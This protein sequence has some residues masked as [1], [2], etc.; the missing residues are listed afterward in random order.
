[1][2]YIGLKDY[3]HFKELFA[4]R[5]T[6]DGKLVRQNQILLSYYKHAIKNHRTFT[7][8]K[9]VTSMTSLYDEVIKQV[10]NIS[11]E[12]ANKVNAN[13]N[14]LFGAFGSKYRFYSSEYC[15]DNYLGL[16]RDGDATAIRYIRRED[17]REFKM[18][19]GKFLKRIMMET[20]YGKQL[21]ESTLL[22]VLEV[23]S[24]KWTAYATEEIGDF[25]LIV[26]EDFRAI[27]DSY[28]YFDGADFHSCMTDNEQYEFYENAVQAKAASIWKND[29]MYARC[30]IF[31]EVFDVESSEKLRL[32][33]RQ[34]SAEDNDLYKNILINKLISGGYI[35]GY[36][37]VG[38]GCSSSHA[39]VSNKGSDWSNRDFYIKCYLDCDDTLSY[40]DTFKFYNQGKN[41]AYNDYNYDYDYDLAT[42]DPRLEGKYDSYHDDYCCEVRTVY[43]WSDYRGEY[44]E[45]TCDVD[46][47]GDFTYIDGEYY[48]EVIWSDYSCDDIRKDLAVWSDCEQSYLDRDNA[49]YSEYEEDYIPEDDAIWD[50]KAGDYFSSEESLEEWRAENL[51]EEDKEEEKAENAA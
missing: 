4:K 38:A 44:R 15:S 34:Y 5:Q 11:R 39:F 7:E 30:I 23:F 16:C 14:I 43:V 26:D 36:K 31:T 21:N 35:D 40:Q 41:R 19:A 24:Q 17:G 42:T 50:D 47:M 10:H 25:E 37:Q 2:L 18:K 32:A 45:E 48:D 27:Y 13:F 9:N 22:Y 46:R 1:M 12:N 33:E 28:N 29:K 3:A 6:N 8:A 20:E 49:V 51:N